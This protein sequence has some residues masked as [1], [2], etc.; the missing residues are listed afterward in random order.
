MASFLNALSAVSI[1]LMLMA[2]GYFMGYKKWMGHSE[3][4]FLGKY[5]LYIAI[6]INCLTGILNN[7]DMD[8]LKSVGPMVLV[9]FCS[10]IVT[11]VLAIVTGN[12]MKL[13]NS[14]KGSFS[15][16]A[17]LSNV[18]FIGLPV[19]TQIFGDVA[20]P[21]LMVY[22]LANTTFLQTA[23]TILVQQ[24]GRSE[25][26]TKQTFFGVIKGLLTKPPIVAVIVS[27]LLMVLDIRPYP[28]IMEYAGYISDTVSA[29]ALIYC[30]FI[31]YEVGLKNLRPKRGH[32]TIV[33]MRLV[34]A[35]CICWVIATAFGMSG[36]ALGVF[37]LLSG[38]PAPTQIPV[39]AGV[40]G[41]DEQ[42][43]ATGAC[44]TIFF[45]CITVPILMLFLG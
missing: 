3:K 40:F 37:V 6:P 18:I 28:I 41:A 29:M 4:V 5:I 36:L 7:L 13:P 12:L 14:Q 39:S 19:T 11:L 35:P 30:G 45:C 23:G 32:M 22:Y 10:V 24:S 43:A 21:Y 25:L 27:L 15:A 31:V 1:L 42:Y 26:A 20:I 38:L 2:T 17:G 9:A 34:I 8:L 44:L 16:M 33:V